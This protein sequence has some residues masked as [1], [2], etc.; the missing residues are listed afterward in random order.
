MAESNNNWATQETRGQRKKRLEK[1]EESAKEKAAAAAER[2][3][4]IKTA[5][6]LFMETGGHEGYNQQREA[7]YMT[8]KAFGANM[9]KY[10]ARMNS[11]KKERERIKRLEE[12]YKR[13]AE[14]RERAAAAAASAAKAEAKE[15]YTYLLKLHDNDKPLV[16]LRIRTMRNIYPGLSDIE[17]YNKIILEKQERNT[18]QKRA[19]R[20]SYKE[21]TPQVAA[22]APPPK[23][24]PILGVSE[25][26]SRRDIIQAYKEK[27][28]KGQYRH[29]N[30]GGNTEE[31]KKLQAEYELA[32]E[33]SEVIE[34][35][36]GGR[37]RTR[38]SKQR[39]SRTHKNKS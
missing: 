36:E 24:Y 25:M 35:T 23:I 28:K 8:L 11:I 33:K 2:Q 32:L 34:A 29:P 21:W 10:N 12:K 16:D 5:H 18:W 27:A 39:K 17:I 4:I 26:A 37:R 3:K 31:F 19:E 14:E 13:E 6:D 7:A 22:P 38:K 30:K 9:T 1:E 15:R 20:G